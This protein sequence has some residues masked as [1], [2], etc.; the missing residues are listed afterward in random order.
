L[1]EEECHRNMAF[2]LYHAGQLPRLNISECKVEKLD[3]NLYKIWVT[4]ENQRYMPTRTA[5]DVKH[6]I[7]PPDVIRLAGPN[8]KVLSAGRIT[9]RFIP[10]VEPVKRRPER[11]EIDTIEGL[12]AVRVQ[13]VVTGHGSATVTVDSAK[14]GLVEKSVTVP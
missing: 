1:L 13:F 8:L 2:T 10:L 6:H 9:D 7:S 12:S 5:Q 11:I 3:A 4:L 14:G